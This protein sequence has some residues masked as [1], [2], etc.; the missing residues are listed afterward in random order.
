MNY[1]RQ[2]V[3]LLVFSDAVAA[4]APA[5]GNGRLLRRE[6][7]TD[8]VTAVDKKDRGVTQSHH[9]IC[10]REP[11]ILN[12]TMV[13]EIQN[14]TKFCNDYSTEFKTAIA[15]T[16]STSISEVK[17]ESCGLHNDSNG[18]YGQKFGNL[19]F[20][21]HGDASEGPGKVQ[22]LNQ[23]DLGEVQ[24]K[25]NFC[26]SMEGAVW[27]VKI[28]NLQAVN[29]STAASSR[30]DV[31][32]GS[33]PTISGESPQQMLHINGEIGLVVPNASLFIVN[34]T[35]PII[36]LK[37]L[38]DVASLDKSRITI[39]FESNN[40]LNTVTE[41]P[42]LV[43]VYFVLDLEGSD[44]SDDKGTQLAQELSEHDWSTFKD[45]I[46]TRMNSVDL[47]VS[48]SHQPSIQLSGSNDAQPAIQSNA[49]LVDTL[50]A[51]RWPTSLNRDLAPSKPGE[52]RGI[53]VTPR[54]H[55]ESAQASKV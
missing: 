34:Y 8:F 37:S 50:P 30:H 2:L 53:L 24:K 51:A 46:N 55:T 49:S 1:I 21:L 44:W 42:D 18:T 35:T 45:R 54:L 6:R 27:T 31:D 43:T 12:G 9:G 52:S 48:M 29:I 10:S 47:Y 14:V 36:I 17:V 32:G 7:L 4:T 23:A 39:D 13:F 33:G 38:S 5:N 11:H 22:M 25:L 41:Y 40:T 3:S 26:L 15:L 20:A 19:S 16:C 28:L